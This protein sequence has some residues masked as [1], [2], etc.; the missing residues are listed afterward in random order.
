MAVYECLAKATWQT[1]KL[2]F[3][4]D[5]IPWQPHLAEEM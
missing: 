1:N 4:W 3:K 2:S 5:M